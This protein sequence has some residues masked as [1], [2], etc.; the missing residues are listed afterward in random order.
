MNPPRD[1]P[2][3]VQAVPMNSLVLTLCLTL[4]GDPCSQQ[5]DPALP[6]PL[7]ATFE[8]VELGPMGAALI[9]IG[10]PFQYYGRD[11]ES[12][13]VNANGTLSFCQPVLSS[14]GNVI[15]G[16]GRPLIAPFWAASAPHDCEFMSG[17]GRIWIRH[18]ANRLVVVFDHLG[19][20]GMGD[21]GH[22]SRANTFE[23]ILSDATDPLV[24]VGNNI[25]FAYGDMGWTSADTTGGTD[26]FFGSPALVGVDSGDGLLGQ[27][28]GRFRHDHGVFTGPDS[29]SGVH[30]L[31]YKTFAFDTRTPTAGDIPTLGVE[32]YSAWLR[33][34]LTVLRSAVSGP[35]MVRD[36]AAFDYFTIASVPSVGPDRRAVIVRNDLHMTFGTVLNGSVQYGGDAFIDTT[37]GFQNTTLSPLNAPSPSEEFRLEWFENLME[38][39]AFFAPGGTAAFDG[40]TVHLI[41]SDPVINTF[42]VDTDTLADADRILAQ[43]PTGSRVVLTVHGGGEHFMDA[44]LSRFGFDLEGTTSSNFLIVMPDLSVCVLDQV[45]FKGSLLAPYARVEAQYIRIYG[46]II[47]RELH[48][49]DSTLHGTPMTGC[50]CLANQE[51]TSDLV[52]TPDELPLGQPDME[53]ELT[54]DPDEWVGF[55]YGTLPNSLSVEVSGTEPRQLNLERISRVVVHGAANAAR[56]RR[57]PELDVPVL[58]A[59]S[60][61]IPRPDALWVK[62]GKTIE[63]DLMSNDSMPLILSPK[64]R[65]TEEVELGTLEHLEDGRYRYTA[66]TRVRAPAEDILR[67]RLV[68]EDCVPSYEVEVHFFIERS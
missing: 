1:S 36:S 39:L 59:E 22:T 67:Y 52:F 10:F 48:L 38:V 27:L 30:W 41:G 14:T 63:F 54:L 64:L 40:D 6:I 29:D 61:L 4:G 51:L 62:P 34:Y 65:I 31:D 16:L 44:S 58:L 68:V 7:D 17:S 19:Y 66:P 8:A 28:I 18:D 35:V 3:R 20:E 26:G 32:D 11:N 53:V 47:A 2:V 56:V 12:I 57:S 60:D 13:W 42:S 43:V 9:E 37:V 50:F 5:G 15:P 25:L 46:Q 23:V 24:G 55:G 33:T 45:D 21:P 49:V